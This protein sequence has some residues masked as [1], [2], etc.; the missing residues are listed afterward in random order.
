V[1]PEVL[2]A[3]NA[4][5]VDTPLTRAV[6]APETEKPPPVPKVPWNESIAWDWSSNEVQ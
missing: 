2:A 3:L 1:T 6:P 4:I 5:L